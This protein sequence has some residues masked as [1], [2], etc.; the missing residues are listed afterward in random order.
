VE[1]GGKLE[2]LQRAGTAPAKIVEHDSRQEIAPDIH[3]P[4]CCRA[5]GAAITTESEWI[6]LDGRRAH[7]RTNPYGLEFE[8][9]CFRKA[10]GARSVGEATAAHTWFPGFSWMVALCGRCGAHL[11]WRFQGSDSSFFGLI[12]AALTGGEAAGEPGSG[13]V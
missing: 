12:L 3:R 7:R 2:A 9:G 4:L 13:P 5:C 8:F 6:S 10:P 1:G 11:G